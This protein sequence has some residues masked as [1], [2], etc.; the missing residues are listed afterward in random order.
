MREGFTAFESQT[1]RNN[2]LLIS[3]AVAAQ[4]FIIK[5]SYNVPEMSKYVD[6]INLMTYDYH[7][8]KYYWPF[9]GHNSP[10]YKRLMELGFFS[11][12]NIEWSANYWNE[13]GAH[14]SK[15]MVGIPTYARSFRLA[16]NWL[17]IP[18]TLSFGDFGDMTYS[19][20]CQFLQTNGTKVVFDP[21]ARVPYAYRDYTWISY[22]NEFS[23]T[24]KVL[25]IKNNGFGGVMTFSLNTDDYSYQCN[26]DK[27]FPIHS[28][29]KSYAQN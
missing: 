1:Y 4:L 13:L 21:E 22:E 3:V 9:A 15:I 29:I 7:L 2:T 18:G 6:F 14:K 17:T 25:W 10:L 16:F 28:V 23:A 26:K 8:F 11:T 20:V 12:M 27:L 24:E 5:R 19:Q